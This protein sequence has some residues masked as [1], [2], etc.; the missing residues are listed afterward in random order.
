MLLWGL[1]PDELVPP[2]LTYVLDRSAVAACLL[3]R[4]KFVVRSVYQR[5]VR[6]IRRSMLP[7]L[8]LRTDSI[9][10]GP[11]SHSTTQAISCP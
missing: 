10:V 7:S 3:T 1:E 11:A 2:T 8:R 9:R 4:L 6:Q 5:Q